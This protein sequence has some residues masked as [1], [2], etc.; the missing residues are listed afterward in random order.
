MPNDLAARSLSADNG[1]SRADFFAAGLTQPIPNGVTTLDPNSGQTITNHF[2]VAGRART[3][4]IPMLI[5]DRRS[6]RCCPASRRSSRRRAR[7]DWEPD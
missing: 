3:P 2:V 4:S 6:R 5:S 1:I 7:S